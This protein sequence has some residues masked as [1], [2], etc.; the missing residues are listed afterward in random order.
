MFGKRPA[1]NGK[2]GLFRERPE[3]AGFAGEEEKNTDDGRIPESRPAFC[4]K[5]TEG[6]MESGKWKVENYSSKSFSIYHFQFSIGF[7][8]TTNSIPPSHAVARTGMPIFFNLSRIM[9]WG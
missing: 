7:E 4:S 9:G 6:R 3:A 8:G 5:G 2:Q 1:A